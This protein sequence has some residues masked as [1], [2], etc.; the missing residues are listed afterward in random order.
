MSKQEITDKV[1]ALMA[2]IAEDRKNETAEEKAAREELHAKLQAEIK[3]AEE[4]EKVNPFYI[5]WNALADS[6][7]K[8]HRQNSGWDFHNP[9]GDGLERL[10]LEWAKEKFY[11]KLVGQ[12]VPMFLETWRLLNKHKAIG[13]KNRLIFGDIDTGLW[14]EPTK[15]DKFGNC[16][17]VIASTRYCSCAD[18]NTHIYIMDGLFSRDFWRFTCVTAWPRQKSVRRGNGFKWGDNRDI[19]VPSINT[20]R[21]D[22]FD[23]GCGDGR[24]NFHV[25]KWEDRHRGPTV[26]KPHWTENKIEHALQLLRWH[27][28]DMRYYDKHGKAL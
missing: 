27:L 22:D 15:K 18:D 24:D 5:S 11:G 19:E 3:A 20:F 28:M 13:E 23:F 25:F 9:G 17:K 7:W 21:K 10:A 12:H 16:K 26:E 14:I 4:A 6:M 2:K 8:T 1:D